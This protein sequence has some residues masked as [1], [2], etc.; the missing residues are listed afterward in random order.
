MRSLESGE[1]QDRNIAVGNPRLSRRQTLLA[2]A[3]LAVGRGA[4]AAETGTMTLS[5]GNYGMKSLKLEEALAAIARIG[6][7]GT[8]I[9][10][11]PEWDSTPANMPAAR[12]AE[13]RKRLA[14]SGLKLTALMENLPPSADDKLHAAAMERL[15]KVVEMSHDLVPDSPPLIQ[16]VL[17]GGKWDVIKTT[18]RDRLADWVKLA[19]ETQTTIAIKPH[20]GGGMSQPSEAIWLFEQLGKPARLRMV[21]DYSHYAYR[22]LP[23]EETVKESLPW[24]A[25]MAVKDAIKTGDKITFD[26]PGSSDAI[27]FAR[28]LRLFFDGGYRGD[29]CCEVSAQLSGRPDYDPIAAAEKSYTAMT[30]V[31]EKAGIR[32]PAHK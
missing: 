24:T 14:D 1:M 30:K 26:L 5:I 10:T 15:R 13:I 17:G 16:T 3:A 20:R 9:A 8:E 11:M 6:Y 27:D 28:I 22:D 2:L 4:Q 31:F 12:R 29:V 19:D 25:H 32:R 7:D 18:L 21:Y 23:I